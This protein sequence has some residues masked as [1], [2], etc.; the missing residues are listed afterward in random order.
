MDD[1]R[2]SNELSRIEALRSLDIL[3]SEAEKD[4]DEIVKLASR[5]C[6][7]PISLVSLIDVNRQWFKANHGLE[8]FKE[9]PRDIA[10]C[11]YAI[12]QDDVMI[13]SDA[14]SDSR[15][16][17]NPL[18]TGHPDI[19]F[20][21]GM[22]LVTSE[23]YKIGTL[24]VID[25]MPKNLT[26]EQIDSLRI[27]SG[28][29]MKL[30]E[31]R[32]TVKILRIA[33][34]ELR[35]AKGKAERATES[36]SQFLSTMSHEIRTPMNAVIGL[37][38]I[39]LQRSPRQDQ[40]Q[41]L[42]LLKFS[43]ENL[44]T[45]INDILDF[46]KIEA[47]KMDMESISFDLHH[48]V[49][50]CKSLHE[51]KCSEK[52]LRLFISLADSVP[53]FLKGDPVRLNQILTNLVSNAIKFTE[54]GFVE[55]GIVAESFQ[56]AYKIRFNVKDSGIGI[57]PDK[58]TH[59]FDDFTQASSDTTRKY[60]G[61][62]LG[63]AITKKL[64]ELMGGRM[65]IKST[66]GFGS[67]FSFE[68]IM[69]EGQ[70]PPSLEA[71]KKDN[72]GK[73]LSGRVLVVE[74]NRVN[75]IV[76]NNFLSQ[77]GLEVDYANDGAEALLL[78]E[79]KRYDIVLMDLQMP[80][81]DGYTTAIRLRNREDDYFKN[82]PIIALSASAMIEVKQKV[83]ESGMNDYISK[84]FD[85]AELRTKILKYLSWN[86]DISEKNSLKEKLQAYTMGDTKYTTELTGL[87]A[88]DISEM[89]AAAKDPERNKEAFYKTL[90]KTKTSI[91]MVQ[92]HYYEN[93]LDQIDDC[94]EKSRY[95]QLPELIQE[96]HHRSQKIISDLESVNA[97]A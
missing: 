29:V 60:G 34:Q 90:H 72:A 26:E 82:I 71:G 81:I 66:P 80:G 39:L 12:E 95:E 35:T 37:T 70:Q 50:S 33:D 68:L 69:Q 57:P 79:S 30:I 94:L 77:W 32:E 52:E 10:F 73:K 42:Q 17:S 4:F 88:K 87:I 41:D 22:P 20:Y 2:S 11:S 55:I 65:N 83:Y 3:D 1:V 61:T 13:I 62:G 47:G 54:K 67:D 6:N 63:L 48:L 78:A 44:L 89:L 19:R 23:G 40:I 85:S 9:T 45:I 28:Q 59:I 64:V 86:K 93:V 27:L 97:R 14:T 8:G 53:K 92:D 51:N 75:Q 56:G 43:G 36:K 31:L 16:A 91:S 24:C 21:A 25:R 15:F 74:D 18:V 7:T 5:I 49:K 38:E 58:L 46:N 76:A 84:P 96:L